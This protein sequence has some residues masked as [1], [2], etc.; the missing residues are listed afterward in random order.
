MN[1]IGYFTSFWNLI[2]LSSLIMTLI[3]KIAFVLS[4]KEEIYYPLASI[5]LIILWLRMFYFGR[6]F[7]QTAVIV[8]MII[9]IVKDMKVFILLLGIS[10]LGFGNAFYIIGR[11]DIYDRIPFTQNNFIKTMGFAW[12]NIIGEFSFTKEFPEG[13]YYYILYCIWFIHTLM[14]MFMLLNLL[15]A[16][17]GDSFNRV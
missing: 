4:W 7:F 15:I 2:D 10:T 6:M 1:K 12:S 9:Q 17:M 11:N 5:T 14:T 13:N 8:A 3:V 16:I